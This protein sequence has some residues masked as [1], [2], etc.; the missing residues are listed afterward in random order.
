MNAWCGFGA[1]TPALLVVGK[2]T[3]DRIAMIAARQI[4]AALRLV[5]VLDSLIWSSRQTSDLPRQVL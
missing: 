3:R 1:S 2:T 5:M 4:I